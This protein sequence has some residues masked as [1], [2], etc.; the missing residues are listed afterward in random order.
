MAGKKY[1]LEDFRIGESVIPLAQ[2]ELTFVVID[3]DKEKDLII[4]GI[5]E[6]PDVKGKFKPEELEKENILRPPNIVDFGISE[7]Q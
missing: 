6:M 2:M 5:R 3:I 7:S 4:C 1:V